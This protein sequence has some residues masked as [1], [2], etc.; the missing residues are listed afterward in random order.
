MQRLRD[1]IARLGPTSIPVLIQGPTG[2]GKELVAKALHAASGRTGSL[3]SFNVCAISD[4]M[5]EDALFGHVRGAFT[6]AAQGSCGYLAEA[7]G[8]T[9]FLDEIG[10]VPPSAQAKLLRALETGSFRPVGAERDRVSDFRIVAA[11]NED[12]RSLVSA[13]AF[14]ADLM[15]RLSGVVVEVPP[16]AA[17]LDDV[18]MLAHHFAAE[19]SHAGLSQRALSDEAV[20][21]LAGYEWPGNVRELKMTVARA[22]ILATGTVIGSD[23]VR[24]ALAGPRAEQGLRRPSLALADQ[25]LVAALEQT[26]WDVDA[27]A[28]SLGVHRA[29]IYRRLA[30]LGVSRQTAACRRLSRDSRSESRDGVR[31]D[32]LLMS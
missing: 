29:T 11:T 14:R 17:R 2:S 18:P 15:H 16:L 7:H 1:L 10:G 8:G 28:A 13:G 3:V 30:R 6:G 5:F 9:V 22:A 31:H 25:Q 32:D 12:V 20:S 23:D 19:L 21:A 4:S 26:K 27:A 24:L